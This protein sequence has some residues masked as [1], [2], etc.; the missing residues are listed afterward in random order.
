MMLDNLILN[1]GP[2]AF[3]V[4][5]NLLGM[6]HLWHVVVNQMLY[7]VGLKEIDRSDSKVWVK[8]YVRCVADLVALCARA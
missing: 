7:K 5:C 6:R 2:S 8:R 4:K 3:S 1:P